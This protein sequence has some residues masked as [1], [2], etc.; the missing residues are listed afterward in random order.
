MLKTYLFLGYIILV[1]SG[2]FIISIPKDQSPEERSIR[3]EKG[4]W[5]VDLV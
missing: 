5:W 1:L 4:L 3:K 2:V